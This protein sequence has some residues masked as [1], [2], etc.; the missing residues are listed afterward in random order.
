VKLLSQTQGQD[1]NETLA[2]AVRFDS[3]HLLLSIIAA[4]YFIPQHLDFKAVVLY[5]EPKETIYI[6]LS[7]GYRD[8]NIV[9]HLK[10][11]IYGL[12]Q[13]PRE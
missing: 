4:N 12:T 3:L 9:A 10:M 8:T 6:S 13:L 1:S 11:Y 2:A 5:G 7:E